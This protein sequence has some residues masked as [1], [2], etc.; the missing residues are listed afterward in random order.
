VSAQAFV[1]VELDADRAGRP[2]RSACIRRPVELLADARTEEEIVGPGGLLADL[3]R[4]LVERALSAEPTAHLGLNRIRSRPAA[5][6][7]RATARRQRH[8]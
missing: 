6:A 8:L 4:R 1:T 2:R 3:T 7:I 5:R